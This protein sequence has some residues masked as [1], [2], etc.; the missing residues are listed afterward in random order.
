MNAVEHGV[1]RGDIAEGVIERQRL[2]VQAAGLVG[3]L[4]Q[5]LDLGR[6]SQLAGDLGPEERLLARAV[7][8]EHQTLPL[9]IPDREAEHPFQS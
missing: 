1:R 5:R 3:K 8:R 6:K 2:A 7:A 9:L 4:E